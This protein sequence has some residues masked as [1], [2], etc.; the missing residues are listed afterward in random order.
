M[1]RSATNGALPV[2]SSNIPLHK[3]NSNMIS[4]PK[5]ILARFRGKSSRKAQGKKRREMGVDFWYE[6]GYN[7][8]K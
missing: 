5:T 6:F 2:L 1:A 7:R 8:E 4:L 3:I